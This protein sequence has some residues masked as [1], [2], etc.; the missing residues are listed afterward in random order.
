[1]GPEIKAP[2][3]CS[4]PSATAT[5][6]SH[7]R[8]GTVS[9]QR[10]PRWTTLRGRQAEGPAAPHGQ[11]S[12]GRHARP[13]IRS[14]AE[15]SRFRRATMASVSPKPP[16]SGRRRVL[17]AAL[18]LLHRAGVD[19]VS[20]RA[21]AE[22]AGVTATALYR[23]FEDKERLVLELRGEAGAVFQDCVAAGLAR[24][25]PWE[26]LLGLLLGARRF[27]MDHPRY[28]ELLFQVPGQRRRFPRDL[29]A[30]TRDFAPLVAAVEG[31]MDTGVLRRADPAET[32]LILA[33]HLH[34]VLRL[35]LI[36]RF[37]TDRAAFDAFA[38]TSFAALFA[39][40]APPRSR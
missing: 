37:G 31:A 23:H 18:L 34:G 29:H 21:V 10:R 28:Y 5:P 15:P 2:H 16:V 11:A 14:H 35:W 4:G 3:R 7:C 38:D 6:L 25:D 22:E 36:G 13:Y 32:A 9:F 33:S 1:M 19:A 40:L 24:T 39:G 12:G 30:P 20:M 8:V 17:E 26:R 27:A